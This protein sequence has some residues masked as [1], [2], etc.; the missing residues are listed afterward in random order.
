LTAGSQIRRRMFAR[1]CQPPSDAV[2]SDPSPWAPFAVLVEQLDEERWE[3]DRAGAGHG[4]GLAEFEVTVHLVQRADLRVHDRDPLVE[5]HTRPLQASSLT[6][7]HARVRGSDD[8]YSVRGRRSVGQ[9][10]HPYG[11]G[12]W[13]LSRRHGLLP[14]NPS[15]TA[16]P[17]IIDGNA[18]T[19]PTVR[20]AS[21]AA[22]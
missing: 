10:P 8:Q 20:S 16:S 19:S 4:L 22:A 1:R 14:I 11:R 3:M 5:V 7:P 12:V 6:P 21:D 17:R 13:A 9:C 18:T 2:K 15:S